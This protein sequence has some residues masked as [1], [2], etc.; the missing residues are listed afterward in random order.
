[1]SEYQDESTIGGD[2]DDDTITVVDEDEED[3]EDDGL[4]IVD[5]GGGRGLPD[6]QKIWTKGEAYAALYSSEPKKTVPFLTKYERTKILGV[7]AQQIAANSPLLVDPGDLTDYVEMARKELAANKNPFL[8]RRRL[9][10]KNHKKPRYEVV[11]V[12]DL[13]K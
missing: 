11:R 5:D 9:P 13:Q 10:G 4:I 7:R 1:M 8:L 3:E 6:G 12:A 2:F